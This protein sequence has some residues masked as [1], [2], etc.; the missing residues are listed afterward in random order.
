MARFIAASCL[1]AAILQAAVADLT[2]PK[3]Y[4]VTGVIQLP[5]GDIEEPFVAWV[6]TT[7]GKSRQDTYNGTWEP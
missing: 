2:W 6:D 4:T 3:A 7:N 5:Y 1:L